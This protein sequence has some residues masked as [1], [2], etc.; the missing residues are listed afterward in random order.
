MVFFI[1]IQGI[2]IIGMKEWI[3]KEN[4]KGDPGIVHT[5]DGRQIFFLGC[6]QPIPHDILLKIFTKIHLVRNIPL[7]ISLPGMKEITW[8][9]LDILGAGQKIIEEKKE[10]G[11]TVVIIEDFQNQVR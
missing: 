6:Y 2:Q 4:M 8:F 3:L 10:C 7:E 11:I 9:F 5:V 1:T